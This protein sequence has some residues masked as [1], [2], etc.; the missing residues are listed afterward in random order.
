[1]S[2]VFRLPSPGWDTDVFAGKGLARVYA[3]MRAIEAKPRHRSR[4]WY[5]LRSLRSYGFA[6]S[7]MHR[8]VHRLFALGVVLI[9]PVRGCHGRIRFSFGVPYWHRHPVRLGMLR[10]FTGRIAPGQMTL[11]PAPAVLPVRPAQQGPT[12]SPPVPSGSFDDLMLAA[13]VVKFWQS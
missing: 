11:L 1:M 8:L 9:Q 13:G 6:A 12:V 5:E 7:T 3:E 2:A 10:R 4:T